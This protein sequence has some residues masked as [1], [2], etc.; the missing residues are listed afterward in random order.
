MC[1]IAAVLFNEKSLMS[2]AQKTVDQMLAKIEHRGFSALSTTSVVGMSVMGCVRLPIRSPVAG[3]QP[4]YNSDFSVAALLN[5]EI[6]NID[7]FRSKDVPNTENDTA[8]LSQLYRSFRGD[9]P[10]EERLLQCRGMYAMVVHDTAGHAPVVKVLRDH[11]GIK[12]L[13]IGWSVNGVL[14][15]SELKA[16]TQQTLISARELKPGSTLR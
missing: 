14:I 7:T 4:T 1:G 2:W 9:S 6:Y 15:T 12:P 8:A 16:F 11:M 3:D 5:G 13:W 10:H